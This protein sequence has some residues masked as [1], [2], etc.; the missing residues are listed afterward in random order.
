LKVCIRVFN[1]SKTAPRS[2]LSRKLLRDADIDLAT[3]RVRKRSDCPCQLGGADLYRLEIAEMPFGESKY[4]VAFIGSNGDDRDC[5]A[6]ILV[7]S[8]ACRFEA[9]RIQAQRQAFDPRTETEVRRCDTTLL[10]LGSLTLL[11]LR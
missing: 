5:H 3:L 10:Y 11:L 4:L 8:A 7:E 1:S 2:R 6:V 9:Q